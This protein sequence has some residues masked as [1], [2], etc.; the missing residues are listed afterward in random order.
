MST[1]LTKT[2]RTRKQ[3][4]T[5]KAD[6]KRVFR[7]FRKSIALIALIVLWELGGRSFLGLTTPKA[8][9]V[10]QTGWSLFRSGEIWPDFHA[11][12]KTF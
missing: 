8:S 11:S 9:E 1:I 6:G 5:N 7:T 10:F 4:V 2:E 12:P 3:T